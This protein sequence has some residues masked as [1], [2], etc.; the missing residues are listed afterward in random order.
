MSRVRR[1]HGDVVD[2]LSGIRYL[3][4]ISIALAAACIKS[5]AGGVQ[6]WEQ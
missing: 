1:E 6:H 3:H 2:K 4:V 5:S